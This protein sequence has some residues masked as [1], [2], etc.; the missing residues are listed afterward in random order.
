MNY[1]STHNLICDHQYGFRP[2][3]QTA[4]VIQNMMNFITTADTKNE[5]VIATYIDL[6]KSEQVQ[7]NLFKESNTQ[8][9]Q[10]CRFLISQIKTNKQ[11]KWID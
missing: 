8:T 1:I 9:T 2:K 11:K 3:N 7:Q 5:V 6:S 10:T 4:H